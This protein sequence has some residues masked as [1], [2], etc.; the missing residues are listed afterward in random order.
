MDRSI[1]MPARPY[2]ALAERR[3]AGFDDVRKFVVGDD[4]R[5]R[6]YR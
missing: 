6:G 5:V 3:P 2:Q 4:G 1:I